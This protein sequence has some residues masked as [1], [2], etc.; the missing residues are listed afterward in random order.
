M[1]QDKA[2]GESGQKAKDLAR[3]QA[4]VNKKLEEL[5]K[6]G[7]GRPGPAGG[8]AAATR[9]AGPRR[10]PEARRD[11]QAVGEGDQPSPG[12]REGEGGGAAAPSR[13]AT[14]C[15][16]PRRPA[17]KGQ[18]DRG[19]R[20]PRRGGPVD[21]AGRPAGGG[22]PRRWPA[23]RRAPAPRRR[24]R[25]LDEA[26]DQMGEAGKQLGQ[27]QPGEAGGAMEKAAESL[28]QGGRSARPGGARA[29]G[30]GA[31]ASR[32]KGRAATPPAGTS[33]DPAG[34]ST[35]GSS[36]RTWPKHTGK[37]W[38]ELPGRDQ[39]EDHP[40]DEGPVR[41]GLRPEHQA[42]LRATGGAEV[43]WA[44]RGLSTASPVASSAGTL[45]QPATSPVARP[46]AIT[47][48]GSPSI[49]KLSR[50]GVPVPPGSNAAG[51]PGIRPT[52]MIL[53]ILLPAPSS[54][55][56]AQPAHAE[57]QARAVRGGR[58]PGPRTAEGEPEPGRVVELRR[59][60]SA[61]AA[62]SRDPA[63]TALC[64]MA[65]LSAGHVPGEGPYG[66]TIEQGR[67]VR[68]Q[69]AA[70]ERRVRRPA[71]RHDRH[72]LARHLHAHGRRGHRPDARPGRGGRPAQAAGG[73]GQAD[74]VRPGQE[75]RRRRA[76]GGTRSNPAT[77][78]SASP[79]GR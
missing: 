37:A 13:P 34:N 79:A 62:G 55:A 46:P 40:G 36:A 11:G 27:G 3:Q 72:V 51:S 31:E 19:R 53:R 33:A 2:G 12:R 58:R 9:E 17:S 1:A 56:F 26:Q 71:V 45:E 59:S 47:R 23:A 54:V 21:G 48:P 4:D 50:C 10:R 28:Q 76:A 5:A 73:R 60:G 30:R 6:D 39:D 41:R 63:V 44:N 32:V 52:P 22:P 68:L 18:T 16:R 70:D 35:C 77:P 14:R 24:A 78:T 8:P 67:P 61:A 38:G 43:G 15:R 57:P 75:R 42:V 65:F 20:G 7:C 69:P 49:S 66:A 29:R 25:P 64:V 74:P